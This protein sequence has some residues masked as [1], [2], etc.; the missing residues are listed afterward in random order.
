MPRRHTA[1]LVLTALLVTTLSATAHAAVPTNSTTLQAAVTVEGMT[2]HLDA[3]Q[4][5]ADANGGTRVDG[6]QG[7]VGLGRVRRRTAGSRRL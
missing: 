6:T 5:I 7:Y 4:A 1:A 3:L 2:E